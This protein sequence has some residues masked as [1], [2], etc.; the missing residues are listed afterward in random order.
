MRCLSARPPCA[1]ARM[2]MLDRPRRR[3]AAFPGRSRPPRCRR[4]LVIDD[5]RARHYPSLDIPFHARWRHF[6]IDGV[7]R[8]ASI[9]QAMAWPIAPRARRAPRSISPSSA[10]CSMPA[11]GRAGATAI[12]SSG[13]TYRPLRGA[14]AREPRDV[15]DG[16]F[17]MRPSRPLR[18]DAAR[19]WPNSPRRSS[20]AAS[21]SRHDNPLRR[22]RRPRRS[23]APARPH[24]CW[25]RRRFSA[26]TTRR[27]PAD[28]S[29]IS[30]RCAEGGAI[31]APVILA[32]AARRISARSG[33]R[34]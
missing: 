16:A 30:P 29:I 11:P 12:R 5:D 25:P 34:G 9:D 3:P 23:A 21:R 15:R 32:R 10:C 28:C 8:W 17:S 6:A 20:S 26:A 14:G 7:D 24:A 18:V 22:P 2:Q 27:G 1:S 31:A 19:S 33:R 4:R 13:E